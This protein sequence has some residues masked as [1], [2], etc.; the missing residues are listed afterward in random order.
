MSVQLPVRAIIIDAGATDLETIRLRELRDLIA[1]V[2]ASAAAAA[3]PHALA[4]WRSATGTPVSAPPF[5]IELFE[6]E[7]TPAAGYGISFPSATVSKESVRVVVRATAPQSAAEQSR[8]PA[9]R[10]YTHR[11]PYWLRSVQHIVGDVVFSLLA[12]LPD[13]RA[14]FAAAPPALSLPGGKAWAVVRAPILDAPATPLTPGQA[15]ALVALAAAPAA[16]ARR[17]LWHVAQWRAA[18]DKSLF[19]WLDEV[20]PSRPT[21]MDA[22]ADVVL[23]R[24]AGILVR[25]HLPAGRPVASLEMGA[26][27]RIERVGDVRAVFWGDGVSAKTRDKVDKLEELAW[28]HARE[29]VGLF[30]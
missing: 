6:A 23:T 11:T 19:A 22:L 17:M 18:A 30:V 5:A 29:L 10:A 28:L 24:A 15:L 16:V 9:V 8:L 26:F 27:A 3:H 12:Q 20:V 14:A 4:A 21:V 13:L 25:A 1:V 2:I 7:W